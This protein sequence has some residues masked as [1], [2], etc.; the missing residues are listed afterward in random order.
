MRPEI[1]LKILTYLKCEVEL[2]EVRT[3][4]CLQNIPLKVHI[5]HFVHL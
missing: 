3:I 2:R 4:G 5:G 1:H